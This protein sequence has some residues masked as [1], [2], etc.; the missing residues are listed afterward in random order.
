MRIVLVDPLGDVLF[1]GESLSSLGAHSSLLAPSSAEEEPCPETK[2]SAGSGIFRTVD[3]PSPRAVTDD[4]VRADGPASS[5]D[6]DARH[7][8]LASKRS[9]RAA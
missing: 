8:Y 7:A 9:G 1:S 2:R 6:G 3:R 5:S 4:S